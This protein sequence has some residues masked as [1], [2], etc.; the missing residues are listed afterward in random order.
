V[1]SYWVGVISYW[2][3]EREE[4]SFFD[5][6]LI[7]TEGEGGEGSYWGG[8]ISYWVGEREEVL[9]WCGKFGLL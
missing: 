7:G 9:S 6:V 2:V 3:G 1:E 5:P 4:A 8:V